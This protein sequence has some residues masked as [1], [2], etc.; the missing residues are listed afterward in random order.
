VVASCYLI[1][2]I[3]PLVSVLGV[4]SMNIVKQRECL[5][6][7]Y[8]WQSLLMLVVLLVQDKFDEIHF[9]DHVP[10]NTTWNWGE[11]DNDEDN[12]CY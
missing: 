8:I 4:L 12:K 2:L 1:E 10:F 5:R 9:S 3:L 7:F 6:D 11:V